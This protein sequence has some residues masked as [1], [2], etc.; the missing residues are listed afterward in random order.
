MIGEHPVGVLD[1]DLRAACLRALMMSR[2]ACRAFALRH[3]W[4][5]SALQ[6]IGH[7]KKVLIGRPQ[8]A[9]QGAAQ[10]LA[11]GNSRAWV[12]DR[13]AHGVRPAQTS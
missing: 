5:T 13:E 1:D 8:Q 10:G 6:F 9:A 4:E 7:A 12:N 3:S 11:V 2:E